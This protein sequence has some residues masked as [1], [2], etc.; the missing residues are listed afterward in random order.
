MRPTI[1]QIEASTIQD[2]IAQ[3]E[4]VNMDTDFLKTI[5]KDF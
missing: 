3:H 1:E 5:T 2:L 4:N